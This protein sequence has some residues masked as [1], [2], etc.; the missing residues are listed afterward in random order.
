M[1]LIELGAGLGLSRFRTGSGMVLLTLCE[2]IGTRSVK[3]L[4]CII[5]Q[6]SVNFGT[7]VTL[8]AVVFIGPLTGPFYK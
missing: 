3:T 6:H 7:N 1:V 5:M 2:Y 4:E 8:S